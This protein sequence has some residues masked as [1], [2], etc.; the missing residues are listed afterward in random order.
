MHM[1]ATAFLSAF[2]PIFVACTDDDKGGG[3]GGDGTSRI[4]TFEFMA[5][6]GGTCVTGDLADVDGS[7]AG[8][9]YDCTASD[10]L[11]LGA[12][13]EVETILPACNA[14][15]PA[16]AT[17]KPCWAIVTDGASCTMADHLRIVA[18]R[19]GAADPSTVVRVQCAAP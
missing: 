12:A 4:A 11:N 18:E 6:A 1:R 7:A 14:A 9:Q 10:F 19:D 8:D 3:G 13:N 17:N 15:T 16:T 5:S 2:L